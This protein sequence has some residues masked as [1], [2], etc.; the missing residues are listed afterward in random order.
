MN[1]LR[2]NSIKEF[3]KIIKDKKKVKIIEN[4][5]NEFTDKYCLINNINEYKINIYIDKFNLILQNINNEINNKYL[6]DQILNNKEFNL[7]SI[8]FLSASEI[9][10]DNWKK[11]ID[12]INLIEE[13]KKNIAT[14]DIYTC[15]KCKQ[16]RCIVHQKQTR[17]A[18]EPMTTFV[19][20][21]VC[22]YAWKF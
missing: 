2:K 22:G 9:F 21:I 4:S 8:A 19:N 7:N 17:S 15:R 6:L 5:I 16:S 14:T 13:K 10:P 20:C 12:R 18:D 1:E 3:S 11:I